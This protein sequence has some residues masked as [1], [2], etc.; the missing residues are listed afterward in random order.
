ML[1]KLLSIV[2][3]LSALVACNNVENDKKTSE[4]KAE[5]TKVSVDNFE[6][7]AGELVDKPVSIKG[8][9]VHVCKHGGKKLFLASDSTETQVKVTTAADMKA[10]NTDWEGSDATI[11]GKVAELVID[12]QYLN[13]WEAKARENAKDAEHNEDHKHQEGEEHAHE[14]DSDLENTLKVI[15]DLRTQIK[16][17]DKGYLSFYSITATS[18]SVK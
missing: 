1:R 10:F 12:E 16:E 6:A 3:I 11:E 18:I 2:V 15:D 7:M 14:H 8:T 9:I 4:K 13:D 17:S 5:I